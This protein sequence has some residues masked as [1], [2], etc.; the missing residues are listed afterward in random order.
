MYNIQT[1]KRKESKQ[2][3]EGSYQI[4]TEK[5]QKKKEKNN[6]KYS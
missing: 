6:R 2:N 5:K 4:T 1:Q 3:T